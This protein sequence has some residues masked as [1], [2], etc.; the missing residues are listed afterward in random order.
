MN[1]EAE[2]LGREERIKFLNDAIAS[3]E[4]ELAKLE[5]ET[6]E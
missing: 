1:H 2:K 5:E 4:A 6:N 3:A